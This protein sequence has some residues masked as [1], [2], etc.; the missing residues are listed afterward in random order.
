MNKIFSK[1]NEK[2][3]SL[4]SLISISS[5]KKKLNSKMNSFTN[6]IKKKRILIVK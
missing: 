6:F 5:F 1:F 3:L 4:K 2:A